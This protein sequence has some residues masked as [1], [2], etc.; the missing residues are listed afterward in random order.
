MK[1]VFKITVVKEITNCVR[2]LLG[3]IKHHAK[4]KCSLSSVLKLNSVKEY[5][6][7][8]IKAFPV[9]CFIAISSRFDVLNQR[10]EY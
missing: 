4:V 9:T 8:E 5:R 6:F 7:M 10:L 1:T 2:M 3:F